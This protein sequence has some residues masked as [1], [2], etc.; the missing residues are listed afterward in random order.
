MAS[1]VRRDY[2]IA[3]VW[4]MYEANAE[5][6]IGLFGN[7]DEGFATALEFLSE[8]ARVAQEAPR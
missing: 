2:L 8:Q 4:D 6:L 1:N 7:T 5:A 3:E